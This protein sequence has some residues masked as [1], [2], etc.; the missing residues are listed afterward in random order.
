MRRLIQL[1][2]IQF[3]SSIEFIKSKSKLGKKMDMFKGVET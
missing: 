2:K 3:H 1:G